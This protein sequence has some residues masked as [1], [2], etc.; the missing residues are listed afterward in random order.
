MHLFFFTIEISYVKAIK[1]N[2]HLFQV[3]FEIFRACSY[4]KYNTLDLFNVNNVMSTLSTD[5]FGLHGST[6]KEW[7]CT[8]YIGINSIM[9]LINNFKQYN[10]RMQCKNDTYHIDLCLFGLCTNDHICTP[11]FLMRSRAR[12]FQLVCVRG[13]V[14]IDVVR[15]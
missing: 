11:V 3:L 9:M 7:E 15:S 2:N 8:M 6:V 10:F 12:P 4:I 1:S 13:I 14:I 5:L